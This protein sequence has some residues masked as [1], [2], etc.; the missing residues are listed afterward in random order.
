VLLIAAFIPAAVIG[1]LLE[2][3]IER[4]LFGSLPVAAA[5]IVGGI[6][7]IVV[8]RT[9]T[10]R[11]E[12]KVTSVDQASIV[13]AVVVGFAQCFSLWPG[14]SRSMATIVGAQLRGF[15]NEAAAEFSFLLALPTLGA[16]TVYKFFSAFSEMRAIEGAMPALVVGNVVA[17][18]VAFVAIWGFIRLITKVGMTPFGIYR[19]II[20]VV[21]LGFIL[22]GAL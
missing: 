15:S 17:F 20:G 14:T 21:V 16:A 19:I 12:A 7:M 9:F 10:Y 5:L 3:L 1:L 22:Q 13:D 8:E 2:D 4:L 11:R 6:V 18:V